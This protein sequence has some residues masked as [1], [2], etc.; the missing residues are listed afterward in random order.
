MPHRLWS[1][2]LNCF[3]VIQTLEFSEALKLDGIIGTIIVLWKKYFFPVM[4]KCLSF[5]ILFTQ[6]LFTNNNLYHVF[7]YAH[8]IANWFQKAPL[9][10]HFPPVSAPPPPKCFTQSIITL[11]F[12]DLLQ[13]QDIFKILHL[14][15]LLRGITICL[16]YPQ[17]DLG[18]DYSV[19]NS[20]DYSVFSITP[21]GKSLKFSRRILSD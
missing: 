11:N 10:H 13:L 6:L 8:C 12:E 14:R 17:S 18:V 19:I 3:G 21:W 9:H 20:E 2:L 1:W 4:L 16:D 15:S 5:S 7:I